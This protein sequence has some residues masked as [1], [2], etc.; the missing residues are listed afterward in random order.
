MYTPQSTV[1]AIRDPTTLITPIVIK[2]IF[3][4]ANRAS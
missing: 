1:V 2:P 3:L 4:Q